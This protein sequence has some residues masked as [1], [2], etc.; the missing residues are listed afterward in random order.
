VIAGLLS[1]EDAN[2]ITLASLI[3]GKKQKLKKADIKERT[4]VPSA[5]PPGLGDVLGKR[6]LRDVIEYLATVK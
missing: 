3:D 4:T 6:A 5:M 2:E 1:A